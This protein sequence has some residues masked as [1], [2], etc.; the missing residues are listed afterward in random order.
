MDKQKA[1]EIITQYL[2]KIY[3]FAIKKSFCYDE[4]E[5]LASDVVEQ[6]YLSLSSSD[7][8]YNLEGYIWRI[9]E[10]V[11]AKYVSSKKKHL[12][13]SINGIEI[14]FIENYTARETEEELIRLRR[15]IAFLTKTRRE[16]VYAFYFQNK[17]ISRISRELGIPVG[18]VKW[19]LNKARNDL[20]GG[21][22]MER[23]IGRLGINPIEANSIGH[24]GTPGSN[25]GPEYYLHDKLNL[26]IVYSVYFSPKTKEEIAQELGVTPVFIEDKIEL[27]ANNGFLVEQPGGKYT[28]YVYFSP[29]TYSLEQREKRMKKKLEIAELLAREYAPAVRSAIADVKEVYIPG[30]NRELLD[31]AAIMYGVLNKCLLSVDRD[32][33]RY[34]IKTTDGGE[35]IAYIN[36][37]EK[38]ADPDYEA[39]LHLP[40]YWVCGSMFRDSHKYPAVY[41]WSADSRYSSREG[42]WKNNWTADYEY[43]YE[44]LTGAIADN[45]ASADK[46]ARLRERRFLTEDNRV[47]ILMV[48]GKADSFFDKIPPLREDIKKQFADFALETAMADARDFPPQMQD[49]VVYMRAGDFID[50][51]VALMILDIL[52]GNGTFR[53]LTENERVT[54][55]LILFSDILPAE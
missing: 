44:Y 30:G 35:Y 47:N 4:A 31:A 33:S 26:N 50:A 1:D 3:G 19:H 27:L 40:P 18:T 32:I 28:T 7:G 20:K 13:V 54:S 11:Y 45:Q 5:D 48:K 51:A 16:I 21:I 2:P 17:A 55:N 36:L 49:L 52:Y 10:H 34:C 23:K 43:L 29:E 22:T 38:Q 25:G 53:E 24:G 8:V 15:E 12:G 14:P 9:C 42:G 6:V 41:S 39:T 37:P 46:F